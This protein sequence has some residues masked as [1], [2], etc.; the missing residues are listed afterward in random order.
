M[1]D[2]GTLLSLLLMAVCREETQEQGPGIINTPLS[3]RGTHDEMVG[4]LEVRPL[5][6]PIQLNIEGHLIDCSQALLAEGIV[7]FA[8]IFTFP[9]RP[10]SKI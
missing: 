6:G 7:L 1:Q 8:S 5:N 10:R 9:M 4:T 2:R 3:W